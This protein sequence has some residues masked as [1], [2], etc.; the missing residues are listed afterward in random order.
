M[1]FFQRIKNILDPAR[2]TLY[3]SLGS[4]D[5]KKTQRQFLNYND[6]SLYVNRGIDKRAE[7]V[8]EVQFILK[9]KKGNIIERN[10]IIDLL[11]KPNNDHT[12]KQFW[13]LCQKHYDI[14]GNAFI[15]MEKKNELFDL[16]SV[17]SL[18]LLQPDRVEIIF[19]TDET[20]IKGFR[21][22]P[23]NSTATDYKPEEIIYLF[24]PDPKHTLR[25]TSLLRSG[26]RAI[27]TEVQL[28]EYNAKVLKNGGKPE[29]VITFK[30]N[31]SKEQLKAAKE[32]YVEDR[33]ENGAN[34]IPLFL[35]GEAD[36]KRIGLNPEELS[37]LQ[38][39]GVTFSDICILTGVP[40]PLLTLRDVK[41]D[42]ADAGVS[43]FL[44]ETI[45][46][47]ITN[48]VTILDWRFVPEQYDLDFIDPT[49]ENQDKII[50]KVKASYE[51]DSSTINERRE[52]LG[53]QP[54][55]DKEADKI[56]VSFTKTPLGED[57][58]PAEKR[59]KSFSHPL[60]DVEFRKMYGEIQLKRLAKKQ[61]RFLKEIRSYFDGQEKRITE[62][63]GEVKRLKK[64]GLVDDVFDKSMEISLASKMALPLI[65]QFLREA[66]IDAFDLMDNGF[67]FSVTSQIES[68]LSSRAGIFAEEIN[69]TTFN[70]LKN[71]FSESFDLGETRQELIGR[72]HEY[73]EETYKNRAETIARTEVHAAM[74]KG[75]T[76]GYKQSGSP[77][78]IW[79]WASGVRGGARPEHIA[80]DGQERPINMPFN[81][82]DGTTCDF[83]GGSGDPAHDINCECSI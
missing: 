54:Y 24:N 73:F 72:I 20:E 43:Q 34:G 49:P 76:E 31:V 33:N 71:E 70:K 40:E 35:G 46:P 28:S 77:T 8:S 21:Y 65:R 59:I 64:K 60:K 5:D 66:G 80:M 38:S 48:L 62:K 27:E 3:K 13:K 18:K 61:G 41:F 11:N 82:P 29:T 44:R 68:W 4:F 12:G 15:L 42:N 69:N 6:I 30:N 1:K 45:K 25:G 56:Y 14:T 57:P 74:Q 17:K 50:A 37:Y 26:I 7:K 10:P 23:M 2:Y 78:K 81:L 52:L 51:T 47:L 9:D 16:K 19:N 75:T 32:S 63:L 53:L 39:K 36:I 79:V 67:D 55:K 58:A 22:T 83:P